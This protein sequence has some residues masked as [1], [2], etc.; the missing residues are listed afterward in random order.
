VAQ[1]FSTAQL[2]EAV[3]MLSCAK[4]RKTPLALID[5]SEVL[6]KMGAVHNSFS[7]QSR[8][9]SLKKW[10]YL[11]SRLES[12]NVRRRRYVLIRT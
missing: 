12:G 1:A 5:R 9:L 10:I 2:R 8:K 4:F 6:L 11:K 7:E 3:K